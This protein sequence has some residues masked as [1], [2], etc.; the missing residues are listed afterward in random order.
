MAI[1]GLSVPVFGRYG[2]NQKTGKATYSGGMKNPHAIEYTLTPETT[3]NNPLYGDN[4]II[5]NDVPRFN[6]ATLSLGVD[7]L[8]QETSKFIL[9]VKVVQQDYGNGKTAEVTVFDDD[10]SQPYLGVGVIEEHQ[11][12]DINHYRAVIMLKTKFN[13]S[14]D[15]ATTRGES[16]EWQT[17]TI[18]AN[19]SRSDE[20]SESGNHPWMKAAWFDT[21]ADAV[22]FLE[23]MLG[24]GELGT[25]RI[26][27][28]AGTSEGHTKITVTPEKTGENV[29]YYQVGTSLQLPEYNADCSDMTEWDGTSEIAA[30]SGQ[31]ILI[32]ECDGVNARSAGIETVTVNGGE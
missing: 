11:I 29:Y 24:V 1:K 14:E 4:Q 21:E 17:K 13:N 3:D 16:V 22:E 27:S 10:Q 26:V 2:Y 32:V 23:Y 20:V 30:E 8:T 15:T 6:G 7:D 19:V 18:D 31:E 28:A 5:E 25:L 9:G 12:N